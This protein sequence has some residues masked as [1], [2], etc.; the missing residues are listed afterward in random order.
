[1][2]DLERAERIAEFEAHFQMTSADVI[3][4]AQSGTLPTEPHFVEWLVLLDR[5]DLV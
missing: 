2:T 5:G 1:M 4:R 3:E